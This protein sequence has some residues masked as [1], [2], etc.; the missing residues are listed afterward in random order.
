MTLR[1]SE[2][3]FF[4]KN[5]TEFL[6]TPRNHR[7]P[8]DFDINLSSKAME[9]LGAV[10]HCIDVAASPGNVYIAALVT[11]DDSTTRSNVKH[12]LADVIEAHHPGSKNT[13]EGKIPG[14]LKRR[15]GWPV[16]GNNKL[17]NDTGKPPLNAPEPKHLLSDPQHR[18]RCIGNAFFECKSNKE[19]KSDDGLL[20]DECLNAKQN[21]GYY[22]KKNQ[23]LPKDEFA[24]K[25]KCVFLHLFN[26]HTCCDVLWFTKLK[27]DNEVDVKK[28]RVIDN[29]LKYRKTDTKAEQ[30]LMQKVKDHKMEEV[31]HGFHTQKNETLQRQATTVAPKDHFL[32]GGMQLYDRLRLIT[33]LDS[34]G[35]LEGISRLFASMGLPKMHSVLALWA[36][37]KH[38]E[39]ARKHDYK[40]LPVI[41]RKRASEK[42]A[43]MKAGMLQNKKAKTAGVT[44]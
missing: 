19:K 35:E 32:G 30:L 38:H 44:Y 31:Y 15:L 8:R 16:D 20:K 6:L 40:R 29:P 33:I 36:V 22:I 5:S 18:I 4:T 43:K 7:C 2:L 37:N 28:K 41:K 24:A 1:C 39:D 25:R 9:P 11:D 34:V 12:S 3:V 17:L 23:H 13:T 10:Q 14:H 27:S 21:I 26:D 42:I